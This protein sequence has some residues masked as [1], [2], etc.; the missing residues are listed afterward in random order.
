MRIVQ[1]GTPEFEEAKHELADIFERGFNA[2]NAADHITMELVC[3][4]CGTHGQTMLRIEVGAKKH[5]HDICAACL[6]KG[7]QMLD[8]VMP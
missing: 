2:K 6:E 8:E 3:D 4:E 7:I 5:P 1:I